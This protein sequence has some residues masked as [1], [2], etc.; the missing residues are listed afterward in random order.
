MSTATLRKSY[1]RILTTKTKD[2]GHGIVEVI[3]STNAKDRHGEILDIK[4]LDTKK[5]SGVVFVN[6]NYEQLPIGKS[7]GLTKKADG[8][9]V[10]KTQFAVDYTLSLHDALPIY[11]L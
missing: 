11:G 8:K 2:L 9:L 10:S 3:V 4:G 1:G 7:L 6:H 5:Y